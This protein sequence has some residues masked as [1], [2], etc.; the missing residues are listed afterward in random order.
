MSRVL[1]DLADLEPEALAYVTATQEPLEQALRAAVHSA[2]QNQASS[3]LEHACRN[4]HEEVGLWLLDQGARALV[5]VL[6]CVTLR[7]TRTCTCVILRCIIGVPIGC[8][9]GC[10]MGCIICIMACAA[11]RQS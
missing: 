6:I 10:T 2:V 9:M 3:P 5:R 1:T 8:I 7:C 4:G 11:P